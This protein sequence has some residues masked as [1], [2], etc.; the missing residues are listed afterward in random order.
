M[1]AKMR[2]KIT[3]TKALSKE[4]RKFLTGIIDDNMRDLV[5]KELLSLGFIVPDS[6]SPL[7]ID[8]AKNIENFPIIEATILGKQYLI[9]W[10]KIPTETSKSLI[11]DKFLVAM[12]YVFGVNNT[13]YG[14]KDGIL[15]KGFESGRRFALGKEPISDWFVEKDKEGLYP[16]KKIPSLVK[17]QKY[18]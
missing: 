2:L 8:W 17:V 18:E 4:S 3:E 12:A 6:A 13:T 14:P 7:G 11:C 15:R 10:E 16:Y 5:D 9:N 1:M